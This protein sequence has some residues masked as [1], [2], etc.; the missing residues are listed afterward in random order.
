[1][2]GAL[3]V[4]DGAAR[5]EAALRRFAPE[6]RLAGFVGH[7]WGRE[8]FSLGGS[9]SLKRGQ[10]ARFVDRLDRPIGRLCFAGAD[11]APQFAGFLTGAIESARAARRI[12]GILRRG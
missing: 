12:G 1:M 6:A 5:M 4:R 7:D 8:P 2:E 10:M 3:G 11:F 9:G